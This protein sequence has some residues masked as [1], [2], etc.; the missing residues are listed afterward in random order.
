LLEEGEE[1]KVQPNLRMKLEVPLQVC[2]VKISFMELAI[3]F[4][5]R[6]GWLHPTFLRKS[7]RSLDFD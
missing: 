2:H 1:G 5:Y 4:F 3:P 6:C 7:Q